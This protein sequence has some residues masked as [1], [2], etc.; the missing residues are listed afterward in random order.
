MASSF[1]D[2]KSK[3]FWIKDNILNLTLGFL[4]SKMLECDLPPW[5][6]DFRNLIKE[7][8]AGHFY[9]FV[10]LQLDDFLTSDER[11]LFFIILLD[12][13]TQDLNK[14]GPGLHSTELY[15]RVND[16]LDLKGIII[17]VDRLTKVIYYL[18]KLVKGE[19]LTT[20]SDPI[21]YFF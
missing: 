14:A 17:E 5:A 2:F 13:T 16:C 4:Y 19:I 6:I 10:D 11:R 7:N 3:G 12:K 9:G 20:E 18:N 15:K 21:D 8:A 1:I